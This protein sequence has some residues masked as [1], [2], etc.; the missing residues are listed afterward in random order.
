MQRRSHRLEHL[1]GGEPRRFERG[2]IQERDDLR[3]HQDEVG[4]A[5]ALDLLEHAP[6]VE[7]G[8]QDVRA[9]EE[10]PG[11]EVQESPIEDHGARVEKDA[12]RRHPEHG[13]EERAI[14]GADRVRVHDAL[15]LAGGAAGIDDVVRIR[16]GE[17]RVRGLFLRRGRH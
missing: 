3:G 5:R 12:L 10:H 17:A 6:G 14:A 11:H 8:M 9:A 16:A 4:H 1:D 15:G 13:G 2:M 7:G